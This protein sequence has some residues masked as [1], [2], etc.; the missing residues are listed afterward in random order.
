MDDTAA[1]IREELGRANRRILEAVSDFAR[2]AELARET[3]TERHEAIFAHDSMAEMLREVLAR[4]TGP[5]PD[6]MAAAIFRQILANGRVIA[7]GEMVRRE[8]SVRR[9]P[10][11]PNREIRVGKHLIG[12]DPVYIAGPCAVESEGQLDAT[13]SA[14]A[15]AGVRFLRGGAFKPRTSPYDFQGL[16]LEGLKLLREVADRYDMSVVT[17]VMSTRDIEAVA[18]Y[19]DLIQIG[20]R[21]MY[22]YILLQALGDLGK[23]VLLKRAFSATIKEFLSSAEYLVSRGNEQ[24]ILCERGS[25]G[26]ETETRNTLDLGAV[27]VLKRKTALPIVVDVSHAAGRRDI[28]EDLTAAAFAVRADG[29]MIE[30]HPEPAWARCDAQQQIKPKEFVALMERVRDRFYRMSPPV[31]PPQAP[32][33]PQVPPTLAP[34]EDPPQEGD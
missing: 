21:N 17:E 14:L 16:G 7:Q 23:P 22:H 20:A 10:G 9:R 19:A 34:E 5:L 30:V 26:F 4:N 18:K 25:R 33:P 28:L 32:P 27:A 2:L 31:P 1:R 12:R 3:Q 29:V 11:D 15:A 6:E 13:A 24:V 8:K